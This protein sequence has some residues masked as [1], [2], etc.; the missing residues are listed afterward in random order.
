LQLIHPSVLQVQTLSH[1]TKPTWIHR[2]FK[3]IS[4]RLNT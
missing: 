4:T 3:L 1:P 2:G